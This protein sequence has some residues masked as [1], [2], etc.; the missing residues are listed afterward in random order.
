MNKETI[1]VLCITLFA[2]AMISLAVMWHKK[3]RNKMKK[4]SAELYEKYKDDP[5]FIHMAQ[6][7]KLSA[8]REYVA[9]EMQ[10]EAN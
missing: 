8:I 5:Q 6:Y 3:D 4:R 7:A 10:K 2:V 9:K 1:A